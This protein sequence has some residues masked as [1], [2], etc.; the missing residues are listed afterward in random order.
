M[1]DVIEINKERAIELLEQAVAERGEDFV[2]Y[3]AYQE[4]Y[5]NYGA[6]RYQI[7][8]EPACLVGL[9]LA[10]AGVSPEGLN[11]LEGSGI[12]NSYTLNR[13]QNLKI[14]PDALA[15]FQVAQ[16]TQDNDG[17]WGEALRLAKEKAASQDSE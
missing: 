4:N 11:L 7:D 16:D 8:G 14:T 2:Y 9:A 12:T 3:N 5:A 10:K 6:C 15:V 17:P 13:P 1:T